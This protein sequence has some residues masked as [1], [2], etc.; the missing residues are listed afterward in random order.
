M[1][2]KTRNCFE[3]RVIVTAKSSGI[4]IRGPPSP[5]IQERG[6]LSCIHICERLGLNALLVTLAN[7]IPQEFGLGAKC[8]LKTFKLSGTS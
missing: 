5:I 7:F 8:V 6:R 4:G 1:E 2:R 3:I